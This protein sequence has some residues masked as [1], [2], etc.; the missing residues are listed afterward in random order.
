[1]VSLASAW[2]GHG[3]DPPGRD[4]KAYVRCGGN[5]GRP[6]GFTMARLC[7][8]YQMVLYDGMT[9]AADQRIIEWPGLKRTTMII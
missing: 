8:A 1:M 6:Y 7:L 3:A 2:Q 4:A 5:L 9:A